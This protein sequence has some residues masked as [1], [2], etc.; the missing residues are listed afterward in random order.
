MAVK[1]VDLPRFFSAYNRPCSCRVSAVGSPEA[2]VFSDSVDENGVPTVII[3]GKTNIDDYIQSFK[4]DTDIYKILDRLSLSGAQPPVVP[5]DQFADL[6][7]VP[8]NIHEA[9][10]QVEYAKVVFNSLSPDKRKEY[11]TF[12][13]FISDF[14]SDKFLSLFKS[15]VLPG[16]EKLDIPESEVKSNDE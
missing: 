11:P 1:K 5:V 4:D 2:P 13:D 15:D 16:Q 3:T 8:S 7:N 9:Y 10:K 14:G 12:N 6:S